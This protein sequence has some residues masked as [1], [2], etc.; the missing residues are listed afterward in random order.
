[1]TSRELL[2][3]AVP[4][5]PLVAAALVAVLP[6]E[7]AGQRLALA[8]GGLTGVL[9]AITSAWA[10]VLA[11][12]PMLGD[13]LALDAAGAV[14]VGVIAVVGTA[15]VAISP[16]YLATT[17]HDGS[18]PRGP[19]AHYYAALLV[20]WA[21]LLAVPMAANLGAA[22]LLVEA[23]TAASALLV[24]FSGKARA[25]E[26]AWKYLVLTSLGL[27]MALLGVVVLQ[28]AQHQAGGPTGL[29]YTSI[30]DAAAGLDPEVTLVA[31]L[32]LLAGLAAKI[33]WAPVHNWLPDAHSEAPPP[34]S[35]LLSA[36][37]LPAVLLVA[38]RVQQALAGSV[39]DAASRQVFILFGLAS[40]AVAVPFLWRPQAWKRLLAYSS[41]EHMGVIA[42]GIGF[43]HPLAL[44][45]VVVH[46]AGHAV[47]K[48]VGFYASIPLLV[49]QPST[50]TR[51]PRGVA[52]R[53]GWVGGVVAGSLGALA[54]LPPSPLFVSELLI[55]LGGI[56]SGHTGAVIAA[57]VLLAL[58]FL[59]LAH[60]L[61]EAVAGRSGG[62]PRTGPAPNRKLIR[63]LAAGGAALL[64]AV[65]LAAL[66]LPDSTIVQALTRG[67][68]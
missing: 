33:G 47:A 23:T 49:V 50:A 29:T 20:F 2:A 12:Q 60:T 24:A 34:V 18:G 37:L 54:G 39:G 26:A 68:G 15:S 51:A 35:A 28:V 56:E 11:D 36:A 7:R 14:L 19:R 32:L 1:M 38:W 57:V 46:I 8:A 17:A 13:W 66:A 6:S 63:S 45:G 65:T 53:D 62:R 4:A 10:L 21:A 64:L 22:W 16:A 52:R 27:A 48:A 61:V 3:G 41:L 42:L 25:L 55:G 5:V 30:H 58:G 67:L 44:A 43:G 59:G 31:Y 9:A 40:L